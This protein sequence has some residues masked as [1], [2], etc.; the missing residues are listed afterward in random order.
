[1]SK[2]K[3]EWTE[4]TWNPVTGC[5]EISAGCK[6]CYAKRMAFRLKAMKSK[7]YNNGFEVTCHAHLID[8]PLDWK[9]SRTVFVNSMSDIFHE[10]VPI[11]FIQKIFKTMN[12]AANHTFQALTK[13]SSRLVELNT[14]LNWSKNIWMGVTVEDKDSKYRI[15]QLRETNAY[16]KFLSLEPLLCDLGE[17]NLT[18]IDWVIVGGESGPKSRPMQ[19]AWVDNIKEQC[20]SSGVPF[21][22]KQWGGTNKKKAGRML[23]GKTWNQMPN[24]SLNADPKHGGFSNNLGKLSKHTASCQLGR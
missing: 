23:Q 15:E 5:S 24:E 21:F 10:D 16:V 2:S 8:A 18:D 11:E 9:K 17:L 22:F 14:S 3:I 1:M 7:N 19:E 6:N 4:T 12:C 13:R 20:L